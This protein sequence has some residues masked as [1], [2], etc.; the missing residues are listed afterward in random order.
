MKTPI[1]HGIAV[2]VILGLVTLSGTARS[3]THLPIVKATARLVDIRDT[4]V[5]NR[6]AWRISPQLRPDIYTTHTKDQ[7]VTFYTDVDSIACEVQPDQPFNFVILLN[8]TDS[9]FTEVCYAPTY[10]EDLKAAGGYT[11]QHGGPAILFR[12]NSAESPALTSIRKHFRLDS[13]AGAGTDRA[14]IINILHWVHTT[15]PHD[16]TKDAPASTGTEDLM[17]KCITGHQTVDCGSLAT[18][19]NDC[20][21][22]LRFRSRKIICLPKDSTDNDCHSINCV[23]L[24]ASS[25]WVWMD[26]TNDAFVTDETGELLGISEVRQRLIENKPLVLNEDA[27]WNH[28]SRV[29]AGEYLNNYMAKNLYAVQYFYDSVAGSG[30]ILLL[31]TGYEGPIPRT[32]R[33]APVCTHDPDVFW[34][35][36]K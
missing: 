8:G 18:I 36:E 4:G 24:P 2:W 13:I 19:L 6:G 28:Q 31:P 21:A 29:V 27:N 10:L 1:L 15:F 5:L 11:R 34:G 22:A 17:T 32:R 30:S 12:Y 23:F 16:G 9:A 3:Q 7:R 35:T 33:F 25:R 14:R 20:Y 26:A